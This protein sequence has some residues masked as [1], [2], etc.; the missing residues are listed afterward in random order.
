MNSSVNIFSK[1]TFYFDFKSMCSKNI[2]ILKDKIIF[3]I[4][5]TTFMNI[6]TPNNSA[7]N[8]K[9]LYDCSKIKI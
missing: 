5:G 2:N 1:L 4:S 9:D 7:M 8:F 6:S 3:E